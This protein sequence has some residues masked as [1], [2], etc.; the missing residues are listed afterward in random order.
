MEN[1]GP[2][3]RHGA[4]IMLVSIMAG[5]NIATILLLWTACLSTLLS[6]GIHPRLSQA[7][8]LFPVFL[9]L[10][11]LFM[12]VWLVVSW[13]WALLPIIGIL[14]CWGYVRDYCPVNFAKEKPEGGFHIMSYNVSNFAVDSAN[15]LDGW[16]VMQYVAESNADIICLQECA[17]SEKAYA[18]MEHKLDS[19]GYEIKG[20]DGMYII[21]KWPF[22]GEKVYSTSK[23]YSNG[24]YA[25]M[26]DLDGDTVLVINNHL[27]SNLISPEEKQQYGNA[28]ASYD[29]DKMESSGRILLSR[30]SHA[31]S[32]RETQTDSLCNLLRRYS[33]HTIIHAG[34]H[35]DTP[36]SNTCRRISK[37]LKNAFT[38]SGNGLGISFASKGFPVRIDHIYVSDDL[39]THSTFIDTKAYGSD[40][41]PIHTWVY[42]SAK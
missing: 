8:L 13:K 40:H 6:P 7:G 5:A 30:L 37:L 16:K 27:Q 19:L 36:V 22:V 42:K 41:R 26:I 11:L 29:K 31:A 33:G 21:S 10:D 1:I 32:E 4:H 24:S 2:K 18:A 35:N 14:G 12:A 9:S 23:D 28:L 39:K 34:D 25:W 38:E 3:I 17:R 20:K 15:N